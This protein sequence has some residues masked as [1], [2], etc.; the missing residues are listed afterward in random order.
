VARPLTVAP[1]IAGAPAEVGRLVDEAYG[2]PV[3]EGHQ[4]VPTFAEPKPNGRPDPEATPGEAPQP[5]TT[6]PST[7]WQQ[8]GPQS[9]LGG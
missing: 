1:G 8:G 2:R 6:I 3:H 5:S 4:E 7:N 9:P